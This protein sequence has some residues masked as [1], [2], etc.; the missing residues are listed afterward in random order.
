MESLPGAWGNKSS[1]YFLRD[2]AAYEKDMSEFEPEGSE[3]IKRGRPAGFEGM[4]KK[5]FDKQ[6]I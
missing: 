2:F 1:N 3:G 4:R 5:Y 6:K